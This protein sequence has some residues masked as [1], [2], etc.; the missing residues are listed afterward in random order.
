MEET[1]CGVY[2]V[3]TPVGKGELRL[4]REG[5]YYRL[6]Y[7]GPLLQ[8]PMRLWAL[9]RKQWLKLGVPCPDG[10]TS[11]LDRRLSASQL[12]VLEDTISLVRL[13]PLCEMPEASSFLAKAK[14][15]PSASQEGTPD[16]WTPLPVAQMGTIPNGT[17]VYTR[18]LHGQR[19][20]ALRLDPHAPFP[21]P[22]ILRYGIPQDLDG[23]VFLLFEI[24]HGRLCPRNPF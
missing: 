22:G 23:S 2:P 16:G 12:R 1:L 14:P 20:A 9:G 4:R 5:A 6:Q 11:G 21:F 10:D 8:E 15:A 18:S 17:E 19:L 3:E 24:R 13:L 7:R